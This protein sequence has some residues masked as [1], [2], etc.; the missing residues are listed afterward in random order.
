MNALWRTYAVSSGIKEEG[1]GLV[2]NAF[3]GFCFG[4]KKK[5]HKAH[6]ECPEKKGRATAPYGTGASGQIKCNHCSKTRHK[7]ADCWQRE[8]NANKCPQNKDKSQR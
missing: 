1:N 7:Y 8:E 2:L 4:C 6:H 5:G 3:K